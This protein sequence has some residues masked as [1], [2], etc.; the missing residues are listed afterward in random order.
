MAFPGSIS[1]QVE[2]MSRCPGQYDYGEKVCEREY[3]SF[4]DYPTGD[5]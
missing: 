2:E 3:P 5:P 1:S 4:P